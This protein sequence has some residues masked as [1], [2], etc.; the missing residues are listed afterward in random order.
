MDIE[1]LTKAQIVMLTL[2]V[3][4]VTSIATGIVTITLLDQAPPVVTQ[5]INRVV[6]RTV[7]RVVPGETQS[8]SVITKEV[9]KVIKE[10]DI[11]TE[12]IATNAKA[13]V[14][15]YKVTEDGPVMIGNGVALT[16]EGIIATDSGIIVEGG[17]YTVRT[18]GGV[19]YQTTVLD[20]AAAHSIALI[21][22]V[23]PEGEKA[24]SL[25]TITY[26]D[27]NALKLGQTVIALGS[28]GQLSVATGIISGFDEVE[29]KV[30]L[31]ED[32]PKDEKPKTVSVLE[33]VNTGMT[34]SEI[35]KG[36]ILINIYGEVIGIST[37]ESRARSAGS[38]TPIRVVK[39]QLQEL[40][41]ATEEAA[42]TS[43]ANE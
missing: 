32:A 21:E 31:P 34:A 2:L 19:E 6:E 30:P 23:V 35:V 8:A 7:E 43:S 39:T 25:Q 12:S 38:F 17:T 29:Q 27:I 14:S 18:A 22:I 16:Q 9:T 24:P 40:T 1:R 3:S 4:F 15:I 33:G 42:A 10:D 20:N 28:L 5:T 26:A 37:F 13:L 41:A 11:L 36:G